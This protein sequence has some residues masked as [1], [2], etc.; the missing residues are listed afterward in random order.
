M[1]RFFSNTKIPTNT[2]II[3]LHVTAWATA[4]FVDST[5]E[6]SLKIFKSDGSYKYLLIKENT[7]AKELVVQALQEFNMTSEVFANYALTEVTVTNGFVKQRRLPDD[8]TNLAE[9][10]KLSSR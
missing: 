5:P 3:I 1:I 4:N 7:G 2:V 6:H 8:Q 10:I 9:R